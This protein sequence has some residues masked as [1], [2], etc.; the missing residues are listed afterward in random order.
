MHRHGG[1]TL[2]LPHQLVVAGTVQP[3]LDQHRRAEMSPAGRPATGARRPGRRCRPAPARRRTAWRCARRTHRPAPSMAMRTLSSSRSRWKRSLTTWSSWPPRPALAVRCRALRPAQRSAIAGV[4]GSAAAQP[5]LVTM[6]RH[7]GCQCLELL[8]QVADVER[9]QIGGAGIE[10]IGLEG[11]DVETA[12]VA[13]IP[14][15]VQVRRARRDRR[16]AAEHQLGLATGRQHFAGAR[17]SLA[18]R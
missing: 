6:A 10:G 15:L 11:R 8:G 13:V 9:L 18:A 14:V 12:G 1:R 3:L 2:H 16:H 4:T 5:G 7:R 17:C